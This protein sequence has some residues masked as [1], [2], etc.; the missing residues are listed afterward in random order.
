MTTITD[1][2]PENEAAAVAAEILP[3]TAEYVSATSNLK[4]VKS[5]IRKKPL[6]EGADF[7]MTEGESIQFLDG[8][9]TTKDPE[10]STGSTSTMNGVY[11]HKV[12]FGIDGQTADNSAELIRDIIALSFT[13]RLPE[14]RRHPGRR[15][16]RAAAAPMSSPRASL[17]LNELGEV[18]GLSTSPTRKADPWRPSP[19]SSN[20]SRRHRPAGFDVKEGQAEIEAQAAVKRVAAAS[21]WIKAELELGPT[22]SGPALRPP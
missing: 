1:V 2:V 20:S 3:T 11:F 19:T 22:I 21:Q 13:R 14:D 9:F 8:R 18:T 12:G 16:W 7:Y 4:L 6:G 5:P 15:A 17:L 10:A